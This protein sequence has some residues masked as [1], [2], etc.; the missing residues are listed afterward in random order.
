MNRS[1]TSL[2]ALAAFLLV[3][4]C[5]SAAGQS[6]DVNFPTP[7]LVNEI[8][9][10]IIARDIGDS[11]VTSYYYTFDGGQGDIFINLVT[12]NFAG[13]VDV[14]VADGL[15][16][17]TK[18]VVFAN[19]DETE[20]G[21]LIYLRKPEKLILRVEGRTPNDD[22]A[23]FRIKLGGSFIASAEKAVE[24]APT[25]ARPDPNEP[26]VK[27]NSVGTIVAVIPKPEPPKKVEPVAKRS[28]PPASAGGQTAKT[29]P[30]TK[31][32]K[33]P[34]KKAEPPASAGGKTAKTEPP[35]KKSEPPAKTVVIVTDNIKP[36]PT[37]KT[38]K[39]NVPAKK[40]EPPAKTPTTAASKSAKPKK[41]E[42][43]AKAAKPPAA[44]TPDPLAS[45]R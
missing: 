24:D 40:P 13:D 41:T 12:K 39:V 3:T 19:A 10:V 14:F 22:P 4:V 25:L 18:M 30:P 43:T 7:V 21:R 15:K 9:G 27:V 34:G 29:A 45:V 36:P 5:L 20:T 2:F 33:M 8:T 37:G 26:G 17:M 23:T 11:R 28:E 38:A 31:E 16:P 1:S 6:R 35:T 32:P 42:S 44:E